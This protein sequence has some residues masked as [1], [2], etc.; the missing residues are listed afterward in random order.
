MA[1]GVAPEVAI[2]DLSMPRLNGLDAAR[3][4]KKH[5]QAI[6]IILLTRHDEPQ[7][8]SEALR[9]GIDGYVLKSRA[10]S[11]LGEAIRQVVSG[12]TFL[13]PD[14]PPPAAGTLPLVRR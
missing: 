2:V 1:I 6:R 4:L 14:L 3:E 13:S 5:S 12:R 8:V 7:Y 10:A 9:A 11:D